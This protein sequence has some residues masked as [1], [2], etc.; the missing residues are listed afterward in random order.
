MQKGSED[1]VASSEASTLKIPRVKE[2]IGPMFP[3]G[4]L[5]VHGA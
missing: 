2:V 3:G 4:F 5:F 1:A